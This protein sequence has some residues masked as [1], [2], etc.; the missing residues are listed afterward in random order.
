MEQILMENWWLVVIALVIGLLVAWWIFAATR[1]TT[2]ERQDED[3]GKD[4]GEAAPAKRN[5]ALIDAPSA[6]SVQP[7]VPPATP[8]GLA[9][10]GTAV[11]AAAD[12]AAREAQMAEAE[13][14]PAPAATP[15]PTPAPAPAPTA[16]A[17]DDLK[18]IKGVGPKLETML[19]DMG[20]TS[21]AQ[22][23]AWDDAEID[24]IDSQLGRFEGRIR[25]DN[26]TEQAR[27]LAAGDEAGFSG[28]FGNG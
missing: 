26:W 19:K 5:Q 23:A 14:E 6:M 7:T 13:A 21:Y 10:A 9:G 15:E 17:S 16:A 8:A 20:V 12:E 22:I 3:G 28:K 27:F 2:V 4:G 18:R 11:A 25:R 24:R 1:K